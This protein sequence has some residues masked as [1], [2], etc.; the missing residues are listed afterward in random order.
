MWWVISVIFIA[1]VV[2]IRNVWSTEDLQEISCDTVTN[3]NSTFKLL[4]IRDALDYQAGHVPGSVNI[5]LG[6]LPY[7]ANLDLEHAHSVIIM[8]NNDRRSKKAARIL[9]KKGFQNIYICI[10]PVTPCYDNKHSMCS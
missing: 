4:D 7:V 6:R 1:I 2:V 10:N 9:K 5:S 8:G 3:E